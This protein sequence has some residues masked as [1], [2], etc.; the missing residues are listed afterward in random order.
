VVQP[1]RTNE[2]ISLLPAFY[3][4]DPLVRRL[5]DSVAGRLAQVQIDL[6]EAMSAHWVD[7]ADRG[8]LGARAPISDL[9]RIASMVPLVSFTDES[10]THP[11]LR[12]VIVDPAATLRAPAG[13]SLTFADLRRGQRAALAGQVRADGIFVV[14]DLAL[15]GVAPI[16]GPFDRLNGVILATTAPT[17]ADPDATLT[18]WA[19]DDASDTFRRRLKLTVEAFLEGS[20]TAPALLKILVATMGWGELLG[21]FEDW[22]AQWTRDNPVF[23]ASAAGAAQPIRLREFPL[24]RAV[25]PVI[26]QVKAGAR[27]TV[28]N[29]SAFVVAPVVQLT[30]LDLP[31]LIPTL[32]NLDTLV[33]IA[34]AVAMETTRLVDGVP[35]RFEVGIGIEGQPDGTLRATLTE[36]PTG[37]Q[38]VQSRDVTDR[39]IV[40]ASALRVDR[41][42]ADAFLIGGAE[43][44]AAQL[45]VSDGRR[46]VSLTARGDGIWGNGVQVAFG[47][48]EPDPQGGTRTRLRLR[49]D[50]GVAVGE[51][52]ADPSQLYEEDLTLAD[53]VAAKS[54]LVSAADFTLGIPRGTS[55]WQYL[56]H[57]S[58]AIF[59]VVTWDSAAFDAPDTTT[60]DLETLLATYPIKGSYDFA[61]FDAA[62]YPQEV[63]GAFRYDSPA[64]KY[65]AAFFS[66]TGNQ[67][68]IRMGWREAQACTIELDFPVSSPLDFAR[69]A[70]LPQM[71]GT[72]KGAGI[73]LVLTPQSAVLEHQPLD[74]PMPVVMPHGVEAATPGEVIRAGVRMSEQP[75]L[76]ERIL[77]HFDRERWNE[78]QYA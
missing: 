77:G 36:T 29:D 65:D 26:Q 68:E 44:A 52:A 12:T 37:T 47:S 25:T 48:A 20:G 16:A 49:Y 40:T 18:I 27:W 71:L 21:S 70:P 59:D 69:V 43:G 41:A 39:L 55:R 61:H 19:G 6:Q 45:V 31:V 63:V 1:N 24:K 2:I 54:R 51:P 75:V 33:S 62:L 14:T 7:A 50:P 28:Q 30:A 3:G 8:S 11:V 32:V 13:A 56:D 74:D 46:A 9:A 58:A 53:L 60:N 57:F 15:A 22:S 72:V 35:T 17:G 66:E 64:S 38:A 4:Q 23:I 67:V 10:A 73:K 78:V 42:G 76:G 5:V 34:V